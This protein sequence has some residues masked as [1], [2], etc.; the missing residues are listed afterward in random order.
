MF[1]DLIDLRLRRPLQGVPSR[2]KRTAL[3]T[4]YVAAT[5]QRARAEHRL[6]EWRAPPPRSDIDVDLVTVAC[7]RDRVLSVRMVH[8]FLQHAGRPRHL[9]VVS[10]G[11]L[12]PKT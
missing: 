7:E 9:W 2:W 12:R 5:L 4:W 8:S 6:D 10:D 1:N 11:S 3:S